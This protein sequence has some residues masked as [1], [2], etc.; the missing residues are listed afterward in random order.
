MKKPYFKDSSGI[1]ITPESPNLNV[2]DGHKFNEVVA[3]LPPRGA[4]GTNEPE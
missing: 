4:I 2:T 3:V 1:Y